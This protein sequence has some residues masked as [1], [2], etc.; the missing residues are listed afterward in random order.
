M[1]KKSLYK[2]STHQYCQTAK[3]NFEASAAGTTKNNVSET[4]IHTVYIIYSHWI[5]IV[6]RTQKCYSNPSSCILP[7]PTYRDNIIFR[8]ARMAHESHC[9]FRWCQRSGDQALS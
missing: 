3:I 8:S 9:A 1:K 6:V 7:T 5:F 2:A 4:V